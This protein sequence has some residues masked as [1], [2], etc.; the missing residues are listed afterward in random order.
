MKR[1][2]A[3]IEH[4][5]NHPALL[6]WYL[7]DEP[8]GQGVPADSLQKIYD[9][10]KE[11]D[12]Y[13]PITIVFDAPQRA[14][15]YASAMDIVMADPYPIPS[16]GVEGVGAVTEGLMKAF[17]YEK[18]V[19]IVPQAFG[20]AEWWGR[21]PS[22]QEVRAMTYLALV[23]G[24]TGIQYFIRHGANGFPKSTVT[25]DECSRAAIETGLISPYLLNGSPVEELLTE[26]DGVWTNGWL[27]GEERLVMVVNSN[28]RPVE[29]T[30]AISG[31]ESGGMAEVM[32]ENRQVKVPDGLLSEPIGPLGVRIY[33]LG[34]VVP[35]AEAGNML[36]DPGFESL[37]SYGVPAACYARVG[38][39]P[40]SSAFLDP[41]T[42][43][44]GHTSLRLTTPQLD[45]GMGLSFFP[46]S[47]NSGQSYRFSIWSRALESSHMPAMKT[48]FFNRL[49]RKPQFDNREFLLEIADLVRKSFRPDEEWKPYTV[50]FRVPED[51][52]GQ[53][54]VNP[55]LE[56]TGQGTA[57]FDRMNLTADPVL[58]YRI[59]TRNRKPEIII[60]TVEE[61]AEVRYNLEGRIPKV[62]DPEY[63]DP[64]VLKTT[65]TVAAGVFGEQGLLGWTMQSYRIHL[66]VGRSPAYEKKYYPKYS[67]GGDLGLVDGLSGSR[68]YLDGRWQ[69]ING[70]DLRVI[71]DLDSVNKVNRVSLGCLQDISAWIF[72]PLRL[73][74]EGS[75]DGRTF[76]SLGVFE[77]QTDERAR[78]AI[79]KDFTVECG[80][81]GVR[82]LRVRAVSRKICPAWH[83]GNGK[84]AF[85]F[86][87]EITVE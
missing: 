17:R 43:V 7:S 3:E 50:Y 32:F 71:I 66:A 31:T 4:F 49:F 18:P 70:Q 35:K 23:R 59:N 51:G 87:D 29:F 65:T 76:A 48:G 64:L 55:Y 77:N 45:S 15:E 26:R 52:S 86:L 22:P 39:D 58:G 6:A 82:Y 85:I 73:E 80:G 38:S 53:V 36:S 2:Q 5:R 34:A 37:L 30:L 25:W 1:L 13:H 69:G 54:K 20:G 74:V 63:R 8:T 19:W 75:T 67:A 79:R 40:G 68:N 9:F 46:V 61:N 11:L 27:L 60:S 72:M 56:L 12:P 14:R 41:R 10:I 84:P 81:A 33:R 57:W 78:G 42:R 44:E 62:T 24:A 28:N 47:L 83:N 21:E 16:A